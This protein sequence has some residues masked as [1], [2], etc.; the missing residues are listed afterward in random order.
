ME[1]TAK[2]T[3]A[4]ELRALNTN[5]QMNLGKLFGINETFMNITLRDFLNLNDDG[6]NIYME[7]TKGQ[8]GWK[9][10]LGIFYHLDP[11]YTGIVKYENADG[12]E[13]IFGY[14]EGSSDKERLRPS[15]FSDTY[16]Y[17]SGIFINTI[18]GMPHDKYDV[19][20]YKR[21]WTCSITRLVISQVSQNAPHFAV[22]KRKLF[23]N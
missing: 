20:P 14:S 19:Q 17:V 9:T 2:G 18:S 15:R 1:G 11:D 5:R 4:A 21:Q 22:F 16:N 12:R 8:D 23:K 3:A 13:L 7:P 6:T 10:N